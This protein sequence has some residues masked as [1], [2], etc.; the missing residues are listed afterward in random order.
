MTTIRS[1]RIPFVLFIASLFF[2]M[3]CEKKGPAE[4]A[5]EEIDDRM[6]E[7][8]DKFEDAGDAAEDRADDATN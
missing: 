2:G 4:K 3:A 8:S 5:G 1:L 7:I 6:E